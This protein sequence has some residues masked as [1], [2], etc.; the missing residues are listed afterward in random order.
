MI[1]IS[2]MAYC[3]HAICAGASQIALRHQ[4]NRIRD[5]SSPLSLRSGMEIRMKKLL[6]SLIE[7]WYWFLFGAAVL[8]EAA[9]F[10]FF[11]ENS[12]VAVHDNLDLFVGHF[13]AMK[14]SGTFFAHNATVPILGG[15]TRDYLSSEFSLYNILYYLLPPFAAYM[16]GYFLKVLI[17]EFSVYVLAKD[18]YGTHGS[19]NRYR[20]IAV[21]CGLIYGLLPLFPAYGIAF[22]SIPLVIYLLR[23]IYRGE[24]P[25]G[26]KD[27]KSTRLNSSHQD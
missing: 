2:L 27:R 14:H 10:I 4:R 22:A 15:I 9:V 20:P 7:K 16:C 1:T 21:V 26:R 6:H 18:I 19:W 5:F 8:G 25:W 3:Y 23:R 17:A 11:G 12:Y 24:A 13:M